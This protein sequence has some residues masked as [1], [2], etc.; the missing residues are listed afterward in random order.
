VLFFLWHYA[1]LAVGTV[2]FRLCGSIFGYN[3]RAGKT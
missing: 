1:A 2:A 3:N